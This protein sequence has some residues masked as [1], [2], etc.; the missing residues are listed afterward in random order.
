MGGSSYTD[1]GEG[2]GVKGLLGDG[3]LNSLELRT[4]QS[5]RPFSRALRLFKLGWHSLA[6]VMAWHFNQ[7]SF[8]C[9]V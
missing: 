9:F 5:W 3:I 1:K 8:N 4:A 7:S 2:D 6:D